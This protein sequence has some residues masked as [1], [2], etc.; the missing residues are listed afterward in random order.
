M[1]RIDKSKFFN[2]KV[3]LHKVNFSGFIKDD[4]NV[5]STV[6]PLSLF[7]KGYTDDGDPIEFTIYGEAQ[8]DLA[9][10]FGF[11][12]IELG[13]SELSPLYCLSRF[14]FLGSISPDN[15]SLVGKG[16]LRNIY[17][18][19]GN[20]SFNIDLKI[21]NNLV[22]KQNTTIN[23][24]LQYKKPETTLSPTTMKRLPN[25]LY[26]KASTETSIG[27]L[28]R[29]Y[30]KEILRVKTRI[31]MI[32]KDAVIDLARHTALVNNFAPYAS[33]L[34]IRDMDIEDW[35]NAFKKISDIILLEDS[36]EMLKEAIRYFTDAEPT[37]IDM[38][39]FRMKLGSSRLDRDCYAID[40]DLR[41]FTVKVIVNNPHNKK[42]DKKILI[43]FLRL[44]APL[45]IKIIM[46]FTDGELITL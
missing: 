2:G 9:T 35:R 37:V 41:A 12:E 28:L 23:G 17:Q 45:H 3:N 16:D 46:E 33:G 7:F 32:E 34:P 8:G 27:R 10:G 13:T 42:F 20:I 24:F 31:N 15:L 6:N 11:A 5:I 14:T 25:A 1:T 18:L 38:S 36:S 43:A 39:Q 19:E 29:A 21:T 26:N 44:F 40:R 22:D 4:P 30:D